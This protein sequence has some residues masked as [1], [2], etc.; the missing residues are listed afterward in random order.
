MAVKTISNAGG[1]WN[2]TATW[3]GGA[4]PTALDSIA[5]TATSG[6]L[7]VNINPQILFM[8]L[9]LYTSTLT[10][11]SNNLLETIGAGSTTTLG[12]GMSFNFLGAGSSQG[13]IAKGANAQTY[14]MNGTTPIPRFRI[15]STGGLTCGSNLYIVNYEI[16]ATAAVSNNT[17]FISGNFDSGFSAVQGATINRFIGTGTLNLVSLRNGEFIIDCSGGTATISS[18]GIGIGDATNNQNV[19]FRHLSGTIVNPTFRPNFNPQTSNHQ[20]D[21]ISGTTWDLYGIVTN[22]SITAT[23]LTLTNPTSFDKF[24]L[25]NNTGIGGNIFT[26]SGNTFNLN[27][28][29]LYTGLFNSIGVYYR[30]SIDL[31]IATGTTVNISQ[32]IDINGGSNEPN[33]PQTPP[34]EVRSLTPGTQATLNV[35]TFSQYV[36]RTR[37]TDINC[38]GG[39]TLYGQ[40]LTLSNT[41][42][43]SQYTLPPSGGGATQTAYTF[44]S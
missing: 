31:C 17:I 19:T 15:R 39:N 11:N 30:T 5:A 6:P 22:G 41:T 26:L 23:T 9:S 12:S 2:N 33:S 3:V 42:N 13:Y 4:T 10:I 28:L 25:F 43:I 36:S 29:N 18:A 34:I 40:N 21:L 16:G 7:T 35:N 38:S 8:D 37:F 27:E 44:A 1:N 20:L 14:T 32:F 24:Q